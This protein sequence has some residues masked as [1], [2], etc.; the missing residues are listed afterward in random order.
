MC[1]ID[2]SDNRVPFPE[3]GKELSVKLKCWETAKAL[4]AVSKGLNSWKQ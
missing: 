4:Y 2:V 3:T 1:N